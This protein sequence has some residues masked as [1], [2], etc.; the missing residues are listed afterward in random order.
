MGLFPVVKG[1]I[2]EVLSRD[3][4]KMWVR[5]KSGSTFGTTD[6]SDWEIVEK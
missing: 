6:N 3:E 1:D 5:T 2:C 4:T